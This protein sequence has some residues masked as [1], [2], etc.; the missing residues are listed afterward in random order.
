MIN[1][2]SPVF[3]IVALLVAI[4]TAALL[5]RRFGAPPD[6]GRHVALD[7]L[8]GYLAFFVFL[9]HS[10]VWYYYLRTDQWQAPPSHVFAY[11]GQ[12]SVAIFFMITGFLFFSKLLDAR[13]MPLDWTRLYV[14]RVLRLTPLYLL[15]IA[16]LLLVVAALSDGF[17]NDPPA[18]LAQDVG[19]WLAFT[20]LGAPDVNGVWRTSAIVAHVTWSLAYEWFFYLSLPLLALIL[21]V[22]PPTPYILLGVA[23]VVGAPLW[24]AS[25][26]F[27]AAFLGGIAAAFLVR[28]ARVRA[29][30]SGPVAS[31]LVLGS[32]TAAI[33]IFPSAYGFMP[34]ALLSVAFAP[35][36]C[37]NSLFGLL[38]GP[39][40]RLLGAL[41]YS[42]YLLHGIALFVLFHFVVGL[43]RGGS[44][45]AFSHWLLIIGATPLLVVT[46]FVTFRWIEAPAMRATPRVLAWMRARPRRRRQAPAGRSP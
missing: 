9:H 21:R 29:L 13:Q 11:L 44:L 22:V 34:I 19:R 39:A 28:S 35:I 5:A 25:F 4:A 6:A 40:A 23:G 18:R 41:S 45:T 36:A 7:G 37:G 12:G 14:S 32:L 43:S 33:A 8:R 3:A 1:P 31:G 10:A 20:I 15:A 38:T 26:I 30:C 24:K 17:L 27:V 2:L 46:C 16:L 42:L